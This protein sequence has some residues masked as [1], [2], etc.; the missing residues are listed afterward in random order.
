[1]ISK[2]LYLRRIT[3]CCCASHRHVCTNTV[4]FEFNSIFS[5]PVLNNCV[6]SSRVWIDPIIIMYTLLSTV[7]RNQNLVAYIYVRIARGL[8]DLMQKQKPRTLYLHS[9]PVRKSSKQQDASHCSQLIESIF[10]YRVVYEFIKSHNVQVTMSVL[11]ICYFIVLEQAVWPDTRISAKHWNVYRVFILHS[12]QHNA[13]AHT[14]NL[15][16]CKSYGCFQWSW[17]FNVFDPKRIVE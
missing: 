13:H 12:I 15:L 8:G 10:T 3:L 6:L 4:D 9:N 7:L 14:Y 17:N 16:N 2:F 5:M 11:F 1:M